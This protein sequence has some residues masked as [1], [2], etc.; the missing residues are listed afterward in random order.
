[1]RPARDSEVSTVSAWQPRKFR[2]DHIRTIR[3]YWQGYTAGEI[4]TFIGASEQ[5][6]RLII[7]SDEGQS[8]LAALKNH[9]I[10]SMDEIQDEMQLAAPLAAREK[11]RLALEAQDERVRNI[12]CTDILA[13]AGHSPVKRVSV[14][15]TDKVGED[16]ENLTEDQIRERI[17]ADLTE[18]APKGTLLN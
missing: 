6:V 1:M 3:L 2:P 14:E 17:L 9:T 12:A 18:P 10:N 5:H 16:V 7:N 8:M 13:I 15:R 4:A 11:I